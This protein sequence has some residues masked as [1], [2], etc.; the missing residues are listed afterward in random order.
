[1]AEPTM[2]DTARQVMEAMRQLTIAETNL[3][4]ATVAIQRELR[5]V[6][7]LSDEAA[8][9]DLFIRGVVSAQQHCARAAE[10]M[11]WAT[12]RGYLAAPTHAGTDEVITMASG[13]T[14]R[15]ATA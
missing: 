6:E 14:E 5:S 7:A 13:P 2:R 11:P 4:D 9:L 8:V 10:E 15:R 1:M 3:F 12:L